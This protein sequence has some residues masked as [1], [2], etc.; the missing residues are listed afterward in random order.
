MHELNIPQIPVYEL[1]GT[2]VEPATAERKNGSV[3]HALREAAVMLEAG[4]HC[5]R[6]LPAPRKHTHGAHMV[7]WFDTRGPEP[8]NWTEDSWQELA[9]DTEFLQTLETYIHDRQEADP[10]FRA[11]FVI[12][13]SHPG[14]RTD[15]TYGRSLQSIWRG[16]IHFLEPERDTS[17]FLRYLDPDR[18]EDRFLLLIFLNQ[19]GEESIAGSP[20]RFADFGERLT[21][22]REF[23]GGSDDGSVR[24]DR[25]VFAVPDLATALNRSLSLLAEVSDGWLDHAQSIHEQWVKI[26]S[27]EMRLKTTPK[28]GV[29]IVFPSRN[30]REQ[31]GIGPEY[32]VLIQPLPVNGPMHVLDP[33]GGVYQW[34]AEYNGGETTLRS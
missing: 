1:T 19:A 27:H 33:D 28:P 20:D 15:Y 32:T 16:H 29:S 14:E 17:R 10:N 11:Y 25:T 9:T 18:E 21:V 23:P 8:G 5:L 30:D 4:D 3:D 13:F 24:L 31:L 12:G 2:Y 26:G 34:T 6:M 7:G 22:S